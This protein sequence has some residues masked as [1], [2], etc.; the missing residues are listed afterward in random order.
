MNRRQFLQN[1]LK[2]LV[3]IPALGTIVRQGEG[4]LEGEF[5]AID[6]QFGVDVD[7]DILMLDSS[8]SIKWDAASATLAI[9][10]NVRID[11][12]QDQH[13]RFTGNDKE[14]FFTLSES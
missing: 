8:H 2:A 3:A 4:E 11:L 7:D 13:W 10:G 12:E 6:E 9:T 1:S 5:L 14:R